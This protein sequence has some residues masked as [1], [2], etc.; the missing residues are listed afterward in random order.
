MCGRYTHKLNWAEIVKL[1]QLTLPDQEPPGFKASYNVAPTDLMPIIRPAGNGRPYFVSHADLSLQARR[2]SHRA[3][4]ATR[5]RAPL[6][7]G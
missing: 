4:W 5:R 7:P 1:Y 2:I 3:A 6:Q